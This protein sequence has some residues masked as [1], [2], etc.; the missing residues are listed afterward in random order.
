[1]KA[2]NLLSARKKYLFC[3]C[4]DRTKASSRVRAYWVAEALESQGIQCSMHHR[5]SKVS[6]LIFAI[7]IVFYDTIIFQKTYSRW[8]RLLMQWANFLSKTTLLDL[9]DAPSRLNHPTTL[10]TVE[11]MMHMASAVTVGSQALFRYASKFSQN[12]QLI[13]SSIALQHYQPTENLHPESP[14]CL[15]WIG[16]GKHYKSDLI[17][18]LKEPLSKVAQQRPIRFKLIGA[19]GELELYRAFEGIPGLEIAFIDQID[20]ADSGAIAAAIR[21]IDI[22]LYPLLHNDFNQYKCGFKALEYMAMKIPVISSD[23]AEN[24]EIIERN[25]TGLFAETPDDWVRQITYLLDDSAARM[26]MGEQGRSV[27]ERAYSI[28]CALKKLL[29]AV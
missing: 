18:L 3:L 17:A 9:D 28:D 15:G 23:V 27:V 8:H 24:R 12:V 22:G 10:R 5:H 13:P 25:V 4:G 6:L 29:A 11:A 26:S 7:R 19:C 2:V 16:N 21:D 20:W 1:M 14:F